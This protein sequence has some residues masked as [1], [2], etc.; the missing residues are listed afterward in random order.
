MLVHVH[1][2]KHCPYKVCVRVVRLFS[3]SRENV[4]DNARNGRLA[5]TVS[6]ENFEKVRQLIAKDRQLTVRLIADE[7]QSKREPCDESLSRI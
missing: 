4:S 5:T 6:Y 7:M 2:I 1:K 3:K